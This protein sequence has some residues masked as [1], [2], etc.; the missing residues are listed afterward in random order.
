MCGIAGAIG[1]ADQEV[2]EAVER[3]SDALVHRGPDGSGVWRSSATIGG[4]GV[5]FAHRRLKIIDLSEGG[6]QPMVDPESGDVLLFNGEI[7]NYLELRREL[8]ARKVRFRS[9]SDSEVL[10]ASCRESGTTAL[11]ALRGMFAFAWWNPRARRVLLAR[12]RLGIKP[13]YWTVQTRMGQRVLLFASEVRVGLTWWFQP[14]LR[15]QHSAPFSDGL[16]RRRTPFRLEDY[17]A[18]VL[19]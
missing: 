19:I 2:M 18:M 9:E 8:E 7:Y 16:M 4:S 3:M 1:F 13:L 17:A 15:P 6:R 10:L 12:D 11:D 14:L 5:V